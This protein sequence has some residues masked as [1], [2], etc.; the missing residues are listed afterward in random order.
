MKNDFATRCLLA[1]ALI[2]SGASL[3][4]TADWLDAAT[5]SKIKIFDGTEQAKKSDAQKG[6]RGQVTIRRIDPVCECDWDNDQTALPYF[7]YQLRERTDGKYPSYVDNRGIPLTG[8]EIFDYPIIYLT[9]HGA[10]T[11]TDDEVDNLKKYL[12]RGGTLWLDDCTGSGPFIDSV[13]ANVQRIIPGADMKL[14][15]R[16]TKAFF[17]FFNIMYEIK[18]MPP[19]KEQFMQPFQCA[20]LNGRP[21]IIVCPNDYGCIGWEI[22]SPPT[23]MNPLGTP[24]HADPTPTVQHARELVYQFSFNWLFYSY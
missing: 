12:A 14:M 15:L 7:F 22:S 8:D 6:R 16:E 13:P 23:S 1:A 18:A 10:I 11:F 24:A 19:L 2:C 20:Y 21:A 9:A 3:T 17:D 5:S 4:A